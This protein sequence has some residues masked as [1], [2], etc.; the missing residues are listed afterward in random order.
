MQYR[1]LGASGIQASVVGFGAWAIGG[2][3]WGGTDETIAIKAI[4]AAMDAGINLIDTA[5]MYGFGL[6]EQ[7]VGKAIAGRRDRVVLATKCGLVWDGE[8]GDFFF[9][10]DWKHRTKGPSKMKVYGYLAPASI[11]KE[12]E[13]SLS[14]LGTDYIDLYQTHWHDSTT[15]IEDT[16]A[17]LLKLKDEGKIRAIG[18]SNVTVEQLIK[19]RKIGVVD[20]D[21]EL[22]SMLDRKIE[23]GLLPYCRKHK[24]AM[25]AYSPLAQG[26][27]T[28]KVGPERKFAEGDQRNDSPRFSVEN[29]RKIAAMLDEFKPIAEGHSISLAQLAIAWTVSQPGMTHALC[30][31]RNPAQAIENAAAGDVVLSDEEQQVINQAIDVHAAGIS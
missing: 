16:M 25:L 7:I 6:S 21:Q 19:Y 27:L 30:G 4:H 12:I 2:W 31:A 9:H 13:R 17:C 18:V 20:S 3:M 15:P 24:I 28:G 29:R 23:T 26:L 1:P 11:R 10:S 22:Y 14:Y 5:P 8:H